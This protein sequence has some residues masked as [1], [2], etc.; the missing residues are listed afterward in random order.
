MFS[1]TYKLKKMNYLLKSIVEQYNEKAEKVKELELKLSKYEKKEVKKVNYSIT[2]MAFTDSY[3]VKH[4]SETLDRQ[5]ESMKEKYI[6]LAEKSI[7]LID[8]L[9][10]DNCDDC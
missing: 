8:K 5:I 4:L 7:N 2:G 3:S 9:Y 1:I 6:S 10:N